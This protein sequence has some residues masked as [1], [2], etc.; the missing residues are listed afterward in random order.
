MATSLLAGFYFH[1]I[2]LLSTHMQNVKKQKSFWQ[3]RKRTIISMTGACV[4]IDVAAG[5]GFILFLP[6]T[7]LITGSLVN[8]SQLV[9]GFVYISWTWRFLKLAVGVFAG[10]GK[11][12]SASRTS[13]AAA[14]DP[15]GRMR[16]LRQMAKW[17]FLSGIGMLIIVFI[18]PIATLSGRSFYGIYSPTGWAIFWANMVFFRWFISF[19]QIKMSYPRK[20]KRG[21]KVAS[22]AST[23]QSAASSTADIN[24]QASSDPGID[25]TKLQSASR[26]TD[27]AQSR[28]TNSTKGVNSEL[29]LG[30]SS[31]TASGTSQSR[32][33]GG[34][35]GKSSGQTTKMSL[36]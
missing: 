36:V 20:R 23:A 30:T 27:S 16:G 11:R 22:N 19:A 5:V 31:G 14:K 18:I 24:S 1:D 32:S 8:L 7:Q 21:I 10:K 17:L 15:T 33:G 4:F 9:V 26:L 2:R 3:R 34:T 25:T 29:S 12:S 13:A 6:G 35:Q 28:A